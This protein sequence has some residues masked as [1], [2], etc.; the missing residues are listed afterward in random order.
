MAE[1]EKNEKT[2]IDDIDSSFYDFRY[3]ENE[4]DFLKLDKGLTKEIVLQISS[5]SI[6]G[7]QAGTFRLLYMS[8]D[9]SLKSRIHSGS[10]F[11]FD[12]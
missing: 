12:I 4:E 10:F 6:E 2:V 1:L 5:P 11:S 3:D 8:K 7:P 9:L